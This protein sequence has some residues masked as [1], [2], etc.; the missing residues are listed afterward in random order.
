MDRASL[1]ASLQKYIDQNHFNETLHVAIATDVTRQLIYG[2]EWLIAT[3]KQIATFA[4]SNGRAEIISSHQL[5]D[6]KKVESVNSE[7]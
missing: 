2:E 7:R 3:D 4:V 6:V 5:R 1:P